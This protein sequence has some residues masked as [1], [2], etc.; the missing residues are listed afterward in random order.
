MATDNK[1]M[2]E[3]LFLPQSKFVASIFLTVSAICIFVNIFA[4]FRL[5]RKRSFRSSTSAIIVCNMA[6]VDILVTLKDAPRF[7]EVIMTGGWHFDGEWCRVNGLTSV[8]FIIV[9]VTTLATISSERFSRLRKLSSG[10]SAGMGG[11]TSSA[12]GV[13]I[14]NPL[15]LGFMIAHTTLSYSLSLLWSKYV[16]V[17]RKGACNVVWPS[18]HV[19]SITVVSSFVFA[20]PVTLVLYN[21]LIKTLESK[22]QESNKASSISESMKHNR[23]TTKNIIESGLHNKDTSSSS[24][25]TGLLQKT[26]D[27]IYSVFEKRAQLQIKTGVFIFLSSWTPYVI[28]GFVG[29]YVFVNPNVGLVVA[30]IPILSTSLLPLF[31]VCYTTSETG[32]AD[33]KKISCKENG[34]L[35][36]I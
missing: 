23:N 24:A 19:V 3:T 29:S 10:G 4:L 34:R 22:Q 13:T 36:S 18:N 14:V 35:L 30:F 33:S 31:Y 32:G 7:Y 12:N 11:Q 8:I 9:S 15:F 5:Y 16:F 1:K 26:K 20:V 21:V 28:E 27:E 25:I 17:M 2:D 6:C